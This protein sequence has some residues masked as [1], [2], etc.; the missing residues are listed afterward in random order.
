M[1]TQP[2]KS[3]VETLEKSALMQSLKFF[4]LLKLTRIS[5]IRNQSAD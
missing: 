4:Q 5:Q 1:N 2:Q 3:L